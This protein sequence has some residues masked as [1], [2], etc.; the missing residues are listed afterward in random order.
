MKVKV[1][2]VVA[3]TA[4]GRQIDLEY[5]SATLSGAEYEPEQFPGLVFRLKEPKVTSLMFRNGKIICAGAKSVKDVEAAIEKIVSELRTIGVD[6]DKTSEIVVQNIVA[7]A[8][9]GANLNL[10]AIAVGLDNTEYEPEQFPGLV[11]RMSDPKVVFLLFG[12]GK[13]VITGAKSRE[14][15]EMAA[16]NIVESLKETGLL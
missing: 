8:S 4:L 11:Y 6:V 2:N 10:D 1:E 9:V 3:S 7:T 14:D 16:D 13:M 5:I 12:S 15:A